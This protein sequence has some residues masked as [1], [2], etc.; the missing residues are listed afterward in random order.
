MPEKKLE[1]TQEEWLKEG[2]RLFGKNM[3]L[4]KFICPSCH[5]VISVQEYKDAGAPTG[6]IGFSCIGRYDGHGDV[7]AFGGEGKG[8][9]YAGGGLICINP[10]KVGDINAFAFAEGV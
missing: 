9:N 2:E 7:D 10:I 8:C 4:W 5:R 6:A 1:F 3:M